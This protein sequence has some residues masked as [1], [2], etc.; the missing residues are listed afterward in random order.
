MALRPRD[1]SALQH[2]GFRLLLKFGQVGPELLKHRPVKLSV[3]AT[4]IVRVKLL[5][6]GVRPRQVILYIILGPFAAIDAR[7]RLVIFQ[8]NSTN[9]GFDL[10]IKLVKVTVKCLL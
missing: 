8:G 1:L 7:R 4:L 3:V 2:L 6:F 5:L 10:D 9:L